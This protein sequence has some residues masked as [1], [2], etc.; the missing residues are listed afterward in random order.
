[1]TTTR[2][3]RLQRRLVESDASAYSRRR[4]D[5]S[6]PKTASNGNCSWSS[7]AWRCSGGHRG[8]N[9]RKLARVIFLI[10][11]MEK[12]FDLPEKL[13]EGFYDATIFF[14]A[15]DNN[16]QIWGL[17]KPINFTRHP[18]PIRRVAERMLVLEATNN[19]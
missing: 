10:P 17:H 15:S 3:S 1:M 9:R 2:R 8:V 18:T 4:P 5:E 7:A 14:H 12:S 6:E 11:V 16:R 13:L 19:A